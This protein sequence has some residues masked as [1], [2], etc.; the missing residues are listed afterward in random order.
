MI[1][2]FFATLG[3]LAALAAV[4]LAVVAIGAVMPEPSL[5]KERTANKVISGYELTLQT[6]TSD[7]RKTTSHQ[8]RVRQR[9]GYDAIYNNWAVDRDKCAN[10]I[11]HER[12]YQVDKQLAEVE[13]LTRP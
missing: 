11:P 13:K 6:L 9:P 7:L 10:Y 3:V 2:A 12:I 4:F 5:M 1:K 8:E